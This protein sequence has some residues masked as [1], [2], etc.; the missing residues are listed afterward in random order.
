MIKDISL[1]QQLDTNRETV[2]M[3]FNPQNMTFLDLGESLAHKKFLKKLII[4]L[5]LLLLHYI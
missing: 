4:F 2:L 3:Y 5:V 1:H